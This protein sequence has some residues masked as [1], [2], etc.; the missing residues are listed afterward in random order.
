MRT[1]RPSKEWP[2]GRLSGSSSTSPQ[3]P[4][5]KSSLRLILGELGRQGG[6][7]IVV[8]SLQTRGKNWAVERLSFVVGGGAV[9]A[10]EK[11]SKYPAS[12]QGRKEQGRR[13]RGDLRGTSG[14]ASRP[15]G[16][17][18]RWKGVDIRDSLGCRVRA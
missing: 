1:N 10:M 2:H 17:L 14:H 3:T 18:S 13:R 8:R 12:Q 11:E 16:L 9:V 6:A 15:P 5:A 4:H 7:V